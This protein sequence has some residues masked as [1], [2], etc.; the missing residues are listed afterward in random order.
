MPWP[1][2]ML[3]RLIFPLI[4][5]IY[6]FVAWR[7]SRA[8]TVLSGIPPWKI[9]LAVIAGV[10]YLNLLPI[11][12]W[13][14]Y[15]TG[16]GS[17]L[18]LHRPTTTL[19]DY[20]ITFPYWFGLILVVE[21]FPYFLTLEGLA[22]LLRL[23][24][25][26]AGINLRMWKSA[27]QVI[28][29]I[30]VAGYVGA[31]LYLDTFRVQIREVSVSVPHLPREL[32]DLRMAFFSDLQVDRYTRG[33]KLQRFESCWEEMSPDVVLFGG[34]LITH[35]QQF[36][37]PAAEALCRIHP[38][39]ARFACM[40][41]HDYWANPRRVA[42]ELSRCGWEFLEDRHMTFAYRGHTVLVTGITHIYSRPLS[43]AQLH[44]L[45]KNA[46]PAEVKI[47]LVHQPA[48]RVIRAARQYGY[49]LVLAG[50]THGGQI[51]FRPFGFSLTPTQIENTFYSGY[52]EY[53][54]MPVIVTNGIGLTLAPVR[55][56]APA[57]IVR[58]RLKKR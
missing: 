23:F 17:R 27:L 18:F 24:P 28:I 50:H 22:W 19:A 42:G 30:A 4:L 44:Q 32:T 9:R 12:I 54:G 34:D 31:R 36:I 1:L 13:G 49:H 39:A 35:G 7:F 11:L 56:H 51:V 3:A 52:Y 25:F 38:P 29:V 14:A 10:G 16:N 58:I 8:I 15:L 20:L 57:E 46:P 45:L 6:L 48:E 26:S 37:S 53:E 33:S 21:V 2:R 5:G 43:P 41:D 40:G 47:L 55:Y